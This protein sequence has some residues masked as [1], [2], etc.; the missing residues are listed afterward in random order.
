MSKHTTSFLVFLALLA[1]SIEPVVAKLGFE[2]NFTPLDLL[3][4]KHIFAALIVLPLTR[5]FSWIGRSAIK[6]VILVSVLLL[7]TNG[8][9]LFSLKTL[10]AALVV[11]LIK[12][13]PAFVALVNSWKGRDELDLKFWVGFALCFAGVVLSIDPFGAEQHF[14]FWGLL[15]IAGSILSSTVYRTVMEDVTRDVPPK[16]VSTYIFLIDGILVSFLLL[17]FV[18]LPTREQLL[19][20]MWVGV[21]AV[22]ANIAFLAA[23]HLVGST[24]MS[25][26]DMLQRPMVVILAV[27]VLNEPLTV[28]IIIGM[29]LVLAG[30]YMAKVKRLATPMEKPTSSPCMPRLREELR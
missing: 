24:R 6:K 12:T 30:V 28:N 20:S 21:A 27:F 16:T 23:I 9:V 8:L 10:S 13:T 25:I 5:T 22:V 3:A 4:Y 17:P 29:V 15:A 19:I 1:A 14:D 26:F 2:G 18:E 7:I 11:M